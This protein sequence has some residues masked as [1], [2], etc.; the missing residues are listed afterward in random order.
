M[1]NQDETAEIVVEGV[2]Y[3][4][5]KT[6]KV[7]VTTAAVIR[8]FE[9]WAAEQVPPTSELGAIQIRPDQ[10]C[11]INLAGQL[12][13]TGKV[14]ER[15]AGYDAN[16]HD[17]LIKGQGIN[18]DVP[19]TPLGDQ[20]TEGKNILRGQATITRRA[21]FGPSSWTAKSKAV[22]ASMARKSVRSPRIRPGKAD[23]PKNS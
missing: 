5:W 10:D 2:S 18:Q 23:R 19:Q 1:A 16:K 13:V 15:G 7:E 12:A 22:T 21:D 4:A 11:T 17:V 9:F 6:V 14:M 20:L 8:T 3:Q